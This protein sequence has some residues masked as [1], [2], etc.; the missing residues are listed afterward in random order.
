ML[1]GDHPYMT[2]HDR[3]FFS[4]LTDKNILETINLYHCMCNLWDI[5][6]INV[7]CLWQTESEMLFGLK[8]KSSSLTRLNTWKQIIKFEI[9]YSKVLL[10]REPFFQ[11]KF[12]LKSKSLYGTHNLDVFVVVRI[13]APEFNIAW[14]QL[15]I[16]TTDT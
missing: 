2:I 7:K 15:N 4:S 5:I 6:F 1:R 13:P 14:I 9:N 16:P 11:N 8:H 10:F 12:L 3:V